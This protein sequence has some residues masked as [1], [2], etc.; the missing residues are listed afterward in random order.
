ML[1]FSWLGC[2]SLYFTLLN[3]AQVKRVPGDVESLRHMMRIPSFTKPAVMETLPFKSLK[4]TD[5]GWEE[6]RRLVC[7]EC[8][9]LLLQ[10]VSQTC[11]LLAQVRFSC[12]T[13]PSRSGP[14][15]AMYGESWFRGILVVAM[16]SI[17]TGCTR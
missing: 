3:A 11:P 6:Q 13:R 17:Y 5:L 2:I 7:E 15:E 14:K 4:R 16:A 9:E 1:R 12:F 8:M 10:L